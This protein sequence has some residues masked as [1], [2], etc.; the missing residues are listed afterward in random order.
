M[1]GARV[2]LSSRKGRARSCQMHRLFTHSQAQTKFSRVKLP[3]S[4]S[5]G[6]LSK[7]AAFC[8]K[9]RLSAALRKAIDGRDSPR[10]AELSPSRW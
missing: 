3:K 9:E 2:M 5:P 7:L 6:R 4:S 1:I 10:H 8:V